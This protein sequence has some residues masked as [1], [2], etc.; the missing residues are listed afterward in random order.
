[1][2]TPAQEAAARNL[3]CSAE[4]LGRE[5]VADMAD[6]AA[7]IYRQHGDE[8]GANVLEDFGKMVR[9]DKEPA[10]VH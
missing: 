9:E 10:P 2:G 8:D 7:T 1:M 3:I 6:H 4:K 5:M